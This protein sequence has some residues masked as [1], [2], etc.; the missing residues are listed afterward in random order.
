MSNT[1]LAVAKRNL[2]T[3]EAKN[4][5]ETKTTAR[6]WQIAV[7]KAKQFVSN[8]DKARW[9]IAGLAMEV[10]EIKVGGHTDRTYTLAQ[11]AKEIGLERGTLSDW[12]HTKRLVY[13]K[14]TVVDR[15]QAHKIPYQIFTEVRSMVPEDATTKQ[16]QRAM[17]DVQQIDPNIRKFAMYEG[18]LNAILYNAQ[19]PIN[20]MEV[21]VETIEVLIK[22]CNLIVNFLSQEL[23]TRQNPAEVQT[24]KRL[25]MRVELQ[26]RMEE[27]E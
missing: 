20:M 11:F 24:K 16:V 14:L 10:C 17:R 18:K 22:K 26:K 15:K 27:V 6:Q 9:I 2:I 13:D 25:N 12:V 19:R 8:Y 23:E 4:K 3:G 21:P 7:R 1:K 5:K